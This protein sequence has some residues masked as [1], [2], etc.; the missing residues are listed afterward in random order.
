MET[1][2][3]WSHFDPAFMVFCEHSLNTWIRQ[4]ANALSSL[5][6][7]LVGIFVLL[8]KRQNP[9]LKVFGW[10]GM[11]VGLASAIYHCSMIFWTEV[12][13]FGSM[14]L[15]AT[16]LVMLNWQRMK[17]MPIKKWTYLYIGLNILS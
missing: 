4:P 1:L 14:F 12:F 5:S 11:L 10:M 15:F 6:Y 13:D 16:A 8:Q 2:S 3:P 17:P 9:V 7:I